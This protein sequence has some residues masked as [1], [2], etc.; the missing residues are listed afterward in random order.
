MNDNNEAQLELLG[1]E[2]LSAKSKTGSAQEFHATVKR[3]TRIKK[4]T[5]EILREFVDKIIVHHRQRVSV[6]SK[7]APAT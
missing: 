7:D 5:P 3:Y 4:L 1:R 2:L 6:T